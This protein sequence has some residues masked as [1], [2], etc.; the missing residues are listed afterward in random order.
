V[1]ITVTF[2]AGAPCASLRLK[3]RKTAKARPGSNFAVEFAPLV[4]GAYEIK[5]AQAGKETKV[6]L[7]YDY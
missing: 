5:P 4:R 3:L 7:S 2:A 6:T 1:P